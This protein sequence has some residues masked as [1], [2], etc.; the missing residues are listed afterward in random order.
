MS[1][2]GQPRHASQPCPAPGGD[3]ELA[4]EAITRIVLRPM[5]TSLPLG[6]LAFGAGA[7]RSKPLSGVLLLMGACRFALTGLYEAGAGGT[8]LEQAESD[9]GIRRQL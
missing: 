8:G 9:P 6:F 2:P 7:L 5:A 1:P 4:A 3:R